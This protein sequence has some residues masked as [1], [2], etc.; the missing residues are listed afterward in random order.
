[1]AQGPFGRGPHQQS[2]PNDRHSKSYNCCYGHES[3]GGGDGST[4]HQNTQRQAEDQ[5]ASMDPGSGV[6]KLISPHHASRGAA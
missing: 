3:Q 4:A 6:L 1:M 2:T 5:A